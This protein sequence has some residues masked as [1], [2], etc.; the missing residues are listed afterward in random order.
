MALPGNLETLDKKIQ[1]TYSES[2][3][4]IASQLGIDPALFLA[5]V[6]VESGGDARAVSSA[7]AKGL[8]QIMPKT[9]EG[10]GMTPDDFFDPFQSLY[11]GGRYLKQQ[12]DKFGNPFDALRAYN[13]GPGA[14]SVD[15]SAGA[16]Y[17]AK[18][19]RLAEQDKLI[20][21]GAKLSDA[22]PT[23]LDAVKDQVS[24]TGQAGEWI[25]GAVA[26]LKGYGWS[27]VVWGIVVALTL[28]A[29]YGLATGKAAAMAPATA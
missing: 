10:L 27:A 7:G 20:P 14:A 11:N 1:R 28:F 12:L 16:D 17:A 18:V 9:G 5:L 19:L 3:A 13:A 24:P 8:T 2:P 29:V 6:S 15:D 21:S 26:A 23:F 4:V 25:Q 22:P